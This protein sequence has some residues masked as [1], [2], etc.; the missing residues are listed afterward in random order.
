MK[1]IQHQSQARVLE[2]GDG[3]ALTRMIQDFFESSR[4]NEDDGSADITLRLNILSSSYTSENSSGRKGTNVQNVTKQPEAI[5]FSAAR[6][7]KAAIRCMTGGW[8][9]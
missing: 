4:L 8:E 6:R 9:W 7:R 5:A 2:R 3:Q 1:A